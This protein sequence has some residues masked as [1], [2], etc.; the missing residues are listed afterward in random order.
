M[1][2]I[3]EMLQGKKTYIIVAIFIVCVLVERFGGL[4]I[5]GF[6]VGDDWLG[7]V[8]AMLGLGTIRAGIAG[9]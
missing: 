9:K 1:T 7:Q 2:N 8:M 4:D 5:P 6:T 3:L